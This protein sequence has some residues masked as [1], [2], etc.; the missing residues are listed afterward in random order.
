[1]LSCILTI[2]PGSAFFPGAVSASTNGSTSAPPGFA[3]SAFS[4]AAS[5][6]S[7]ERTVSKAFAITAGWYAHNIECVI[8]G[9]VLPPYDHITRVRAPLVDVFR[10]STTSRDTVQAPGNLLTTSYQ[11]SF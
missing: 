11:A 3:M 2:E 10:L 6:P 4:A 5:F 7:S 1:M 9:G 8:A